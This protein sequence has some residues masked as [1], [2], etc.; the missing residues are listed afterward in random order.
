MKV[1]VPQRAWRG[2]GQVTHLV[3]LQEVLAGPQT[4]YEVE[5]R[6][7]HKRGHYV[8]VEYRQSRYVVRHHH[9]QLYAPPR[10]HQWVQIDGEF[11]LVAV[12]T[13]LIAHAIFSR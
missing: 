12:A 6:L 13:G 1:R 3:F 11:L 10:G 8:P 5:F 7:R 9:P 2:A 4:S